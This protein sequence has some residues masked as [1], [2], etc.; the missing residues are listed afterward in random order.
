M[1]KDIS[2]RQLNPNFYIADKWLPT[3]VKFY[4]EEKQWLPAEVLKNPLF[5]LADAIETVIVV[6]TY[7]PEIAH[8]LLKQDI[9]PLFSPEEYREKVYKGILALNETEDYDFRP[10]ADAQLLLRSMFEQ[11][12]AY[13]MDKF[14]ME[15]SIVPAENDGEKIKKFTS[16]MQRITRAHVHQIMKMLEIRDKPNY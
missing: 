8:R 15:I 9:D 14:G 3:L 6:N 13:A 10:L 16:T 2:T 4:A 12:A 1:S 7:H 5:D 11:D